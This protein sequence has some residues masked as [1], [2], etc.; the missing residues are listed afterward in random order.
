MPF[1]YD[2]HWRLALGDI[3]QCVLGT[4]AVL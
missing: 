4:L 1:I 2:L 3:G